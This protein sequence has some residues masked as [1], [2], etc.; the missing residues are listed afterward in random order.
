MERDRS[1]NFKLFVP[2]WVN[3]GQLSAVRP[4]EVTENC[5]NFMN[6]LQEVSKISQFFNQQ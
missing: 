2:P 1:F 4:Q 3:N 6:T 5:G